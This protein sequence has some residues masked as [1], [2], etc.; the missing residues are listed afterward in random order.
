LICS[1]YLLRFRLENFESSRPEDYYLPPDSEKQKLCEKKGMKKWQCHNYITVLLPIASSKQVLI[2][3]T[4]AFSPECEIRQL[5]SLS[6]VVRRE[7]AISKSAFSPLWNTSSLITQ[8][9]DYYYAGPLDFRGVDAAIIRHSSSSLSSLLKTSSSNSSSSGGGGSGGSDSSSNGAT[10]IGSSNRK[11]I[12]RT[13]QS[14]SKWINADANF[15]FNF[16]YEN[17]IY[18]LFRESAVEYI[19]CG[20]SIYS[21]IGRVCKNDLGGQVYYKE[22]WTSFIKSRLNCSIPGL[23]PFYFDELQS[24]DW[25]PSSDVPTIYATFNTPEYETNDYY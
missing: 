4:N 20:K 6:T 21:R 2:C 13:L 15:I 1:D 9:G 11:S 23:F 14:D 5:S 17:H 19:N 24:V 10:I 7:S 12:L 22:N 25:L 18:F 8:S 16:E 3:G